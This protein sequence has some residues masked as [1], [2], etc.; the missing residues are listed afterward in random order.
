MHAIGRSLALSAVM[1]IGILR[2]PILFIAA[3]L[4]LGACIVLLR[5]LDTL[6]RRDRP[7]RRADGRDAPC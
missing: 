6:N 3:I 4:A 2:H 5:S 7:R 1:W